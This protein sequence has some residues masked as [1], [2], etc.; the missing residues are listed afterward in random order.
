MM[1]WS[2]LIAG[3]ALILLLV[4]FIFVRPHL[5]FRASSEAVSINGAIPSDVEIYISPRGEILLRNGGPQGH[6]E[7][8][9]RVERHE[10]G[11]PNSGNFI[12]LVLRVQQ[13][14]KPSSRCKYESR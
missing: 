11:I 5:W 7:Y 8:I 12:S 6:E 3:L 10:L 13:R 14:A 2:I 9:I 4:G 1:K